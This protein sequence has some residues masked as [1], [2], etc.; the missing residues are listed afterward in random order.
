[1]DPLRAKILIVN[2]GG[3]VRE[4]LARTP[5]P[6]SLQARTVGGAGNDLYGADENA[7][8]AVVVDLRMPFVDGLGFL[9][10]VRASAEQRPPPVGIETGDYFFEDE[11]SSVRVALGS[12]PMWLEDFVGLAHGPLGA[13]H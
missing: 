1:M 7:P 8:G 2:Y 3:A 10:R 6:K 12:K 13:T 4:A 11:F 5:R 9:R